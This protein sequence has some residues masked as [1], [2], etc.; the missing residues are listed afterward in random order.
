MVTGALF[1]ID[2]TFLLQTNETAFL[3]APLLVDKNGRD[4]TRTFGIMRDLLRLRKKFGI[5]RA[6]VLVGEESVAA[7]SEAVLEDLLS[8]LHSIKATVVHQDSARILDI[9]AQLAS[10][11][12]W[13]ISAD[14]SLHQLVTD[15]FG[16]IHPR[17]A[18]AAEIVTKAVLTDLGVR[19]DLVPAI[20]ALSEGENAP[21]KRQQ[22][23][24]VLEV[25]GS[26]ETAL[27]DA[28]SVRSSAWKRKLASKKGDLLQVEAGARVRSVK[29]AESAESISDRFIEDSDE[30]AGVLKAYGFWSLIR[31]LPLPDVKSITDVSSNERKT[32]YRAIRN[33][34]DL[35]ALEGYLSKAA[36]C[37]IDTETSGKDP[38][39]ATLFGIS[40]SVKERQAFFVPMMKSDLEGLSPEDVCVRSEQGPFTRAETRW[41]QFQIRLRRSSAER[42]QCPSASFRYYDS[43]LRMLWRLGILE[44][45]GNC[46]ETSW[47]IGE[48]V[49]R[50][51]RYRRNILG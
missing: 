43:C 41:A 13:V 4:H 16:I 47:R 29:L 18:A 33:H 38:Q 23:V 44:P 39:S 19:P 46:K 48:A 24:R 1:L 45:I 50:H 42:H 9:C 12:Q 6:V 36:V 51:R 31:E 15:S 26:L 11:A 2:S 20:F 35:C 25:Y 10:S 32:D 8:F 17:E 34:A 28:S 22:A 40:L 7:T 3:G 27:G 30:S 37:A 5:R 49:S 21:L 14:R